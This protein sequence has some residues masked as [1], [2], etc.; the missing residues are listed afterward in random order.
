MTKKSGLFVCSF[1]IFLNKTNNGKNMSPVPIEKGVRKTMKAIMLMA[2]CMQCAI[3]PPYKAHGSCAFVGIYN[4]SSRSCKVVLKV[5]QLGESRFQ[6]E[7][8][9]DQGGHPPRVGK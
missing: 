9:R 8:H 1:S 5:Q 2:F 4:C 7:I 3:V 6:H